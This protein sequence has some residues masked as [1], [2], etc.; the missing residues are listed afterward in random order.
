MKKTSV[1]QPEPST[2]EA[3]KTITIDGVEYPV[4][5]NATGIV[6]AVEQGVEPEQMT[7]LMDSEYYDGLV[8][9]VDEYKELLSDYK[10]VYGGFV[11]T[12]VELNTLKV[13]HEQLAKVAD[14][15]QA[16]LAQLRVNVGITDAPKL[17]SMGLPAIL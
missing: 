14:E 16:S 17:D 12:L 5:G 8:G 4:I 6:Q 7:G 9:A 11:T 2:A 13:E 3:P 1:T 10:R 15:L